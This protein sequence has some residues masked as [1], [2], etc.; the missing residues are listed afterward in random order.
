MKLIV[1]FFFQPG[2]HAAKI[3][4]CCTLTLNDLPYL[5]TCSDDTTVK[6]SK[7]THECA[8]SCVPVPVS[9]MSRHI[10]NVKCGC[11]TR[12]LHTDGSHV[13][14]SGGG[15]A[16]L[17]ATLITGG[18]ISIFVDLYGLFHLSITLRSC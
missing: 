15:R 9:A 14:I 16:Q 8:A 4:A 10:S 1:K 7:L 11:L 2:M 5:I 17:V 12:S 13:F 18:E 3:T 6:L